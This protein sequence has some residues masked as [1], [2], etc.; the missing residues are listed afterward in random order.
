MG[1]ARDRFVELRN[2][3]LLVAAMRFPLAAGHGRL[4][5]LDD[6]HSR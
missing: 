4:L 1:G 3:Q 5:R 6:A 2:S